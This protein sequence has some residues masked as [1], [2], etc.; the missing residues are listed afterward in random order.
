MFLAHPDHN[1]CLSLQV[2]WFHLCPRTPSPKSR[3]PKV[4]SSSLTPRGQ[5]LAAKCRL[6]FPF[7]FGTLRR[8]PFSVT[9]AGEDIKRGLIIGLCGT[10]TFKAIGKGMALAYTIWGNNW[11]IKATIYYGKGNGMSLY[12]GK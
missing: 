5:V 7:R 10:A 1:V 6:V 2:D 4:T 12:I 3:L 11:F 9:L 8:S